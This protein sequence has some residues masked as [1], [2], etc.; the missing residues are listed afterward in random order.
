[1]LLL[2]LQRIL[3]LSIYQSLLFLKLLNVKWQRRNFLRK[4]EQSS[5]EPGEDH[6]DS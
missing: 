1:M 6:D 2:F 3:N 5:G 4:K